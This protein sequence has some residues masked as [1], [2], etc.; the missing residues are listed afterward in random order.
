M[1]VKYNIS[2]NNWVLPVQLKYNNKTV[3]SITEMADSFKDF[4][5]NIGNSVEEK[6]LKSKKV[7]SDFL[8][9]QNSNSI[10]LSP[11]DNDEVITLISKLNVSK[12]CGPNS[13]PS[14]I[15]LWFKPLYRK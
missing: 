3:T 6:I 14:N 9:E 12:A 10:F 8:G 11:V 7:F 2:K 4:V 5:V 15:V 1:F 13:I